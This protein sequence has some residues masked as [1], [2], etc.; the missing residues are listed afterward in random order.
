MNLSEYY[1]AE[2]VLEAETQALAAWCAAHGRAGPAGADQPSTQSMLAGV[3]VTA[4]TSSD[5]AVA[6]ATAEVSTALAQR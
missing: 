2:R 4:S 1:N 3:T 6:T 5:G